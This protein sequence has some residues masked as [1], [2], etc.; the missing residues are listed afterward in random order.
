[1]PS[2]VIQFPFAAGLE[3]G[4]DPKALP[5]G[6]L[7]V[8]EN[9]RSDKEGRIAK[10]YGTRGLAKTLVGGGSLAAGK[11][12]VSRGN[13]IAVVDGTNLYTYADALSSW[14]QIQ[15]PAPLKVTSRTLVDTTKSANTADIAMYGNLLATVYVAGTGGS[16]G[17][18]YL[19]VED[20]TT[21]AKVLIPTRIDTVGM[22][23]RLQ[24]RGSTLVI[25]YLSV[26]TIFARE[27]NMATLAFVGGAHSLT[28]TAAAG[29][30][31]DA[32]ITSNGTLWLAYQT[33]APTVLVVSFDASYTGLNSSPS[34]DAGVNLRAISI[35]VGLGEQVWLAWSITNTVTTKISTLST[36]NLAQIVAPVQQFANSSDYVFIARVS[37]TQALFG[38]CP[39]S[40][41]TTSEYLKTYPVASNTCAQ[42]GGTT[43]RET[44]GLTAPSRPWLV[45]G[46]WFCLATVLQHTYTVGAT[47]AIASASCVVV[48]ILTTN[49]SFQPHRHVATLQ[50][51]TGWYGGVVVGHTPQ[52]A[53]AADGVTVYIP[54]PYRDREPTV[55]ENVPVG[56]SLFKVEM[57]VP[58]THRPS[59]LG[60]NVILASAA[61][62][63][64]TGANV[65]P[66]GFA[67][68]PTI[69][70]LS[71]GGGGSGS[72]ATGTY[73][74]SAVYEWRDENG[75]RHRSAPAIPKTITGVAASG[76]VSVKVSCASLSGKQDYETTGLGTNTANP[77]MIR[78]YRSLVG[79]TGALYSLTHEPQANVLLNDPTAPDATFVDTR[80]DESI[81]GGAPAI[82]LSTQQQ[83]YTSGGELEDHA[84]PAFMTS[85]VHRNRIFGIGPDLRTVHASKDFSVDT[86][87]APGFHV[88]LTLGFDTDK[89]ALGILDGRLVVM[90]PD[91][92]HIVDGDG[93]GPDGTQNT[94]STFRVQT[95]R[96]CL[97]PRSVVTT[98][99]GIMF[100]SAKGLVLLDRGLNVSWVGRA[101]QDELASYPTITSAVLVGDQHE[102][103]F[104][105][106]NAANT[107]GIVIVYDYARN[108]WFTR[109]Y[110]D[111]SDTAA[112]SVAFADALLSNNVYTVVTNGGQV[113]QE[114]QTTFLDAGTTW[115]TRDV[116]SAWI[117]PG[118][119]LAWH[120][121][122]A[123]QILGTNVSNHDLE[124]SVA[125]DYA[126][127]WD[128]V[129]PF[130]AG[131]EATTIGPIQKAQVI[132]KVQ[133][134]QAT[135]LRLRDLTPTGQAVGTGAGPI[136]EGFAL[137]MRVKPGLP[138]P[139]AVEEG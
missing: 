6:T 58:D 5:P 83:L 84:P 117:S 80:A 28:V 71:A 56:F 127:S 38:C 95:D 103:R 53:I 31:I 23:P 121:I 68:A 29:T 52:A 64:Y 81:T 139:A 102:V 62:S 87:T 34:Q 129:R 37:P 118:G 123:I 134:V 128:D 1:M 101:V 45:N 8:A 20:V 108:A 74:Y 60:P 124:M 96:G 14:Q 3:E 51:L 10:R 35:D 2:S 104:T 120:R 112:A 99:D 36:V 114:D 9:C 11:R 110:T 132:P 32:K 46:R 79:G 69:V 7:L 113:Y 98:P 133:K 131:T 4:A 78:L 75:I 73:V 39:T 54:A 48:E 40:S 111:T 66:A 105:C 135:R 90:G 100:L 17:P 92:I 116:Q 13:D 42:T 43:D 21:R 82:P 67:H 89:T 61:P 18:I 76:S 12:L 93:P 50:N 125:H 22:F 26:N 27:F 19:Q 41:G 85:I 107:A 16:G 119:K 33:T 70:S 77:V 130:A 25:I 122:S 138:R 30:P 15:R 97:E 44:Y 136:W 126:S 59:I 91:T 86:T 49:T 55:Y 57:N 94:W 65:W 72:M 106:V 63:Y 109:K 24:L 115:V 88:D 47:D 137:K